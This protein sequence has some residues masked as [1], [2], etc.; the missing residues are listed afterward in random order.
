MQETDVIDEKETVDEKEE[1]DVVSCQPLLES[2]PTHVMGA[3]LT[4]S[5][6]LLH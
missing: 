3:N 1:M 6:Y 5:S 4:D 2:E